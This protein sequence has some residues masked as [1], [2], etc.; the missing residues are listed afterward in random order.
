[1]SNS[2]LLD[3]VAL[4]GL[5][6]VNSKYHKPVVELVKSKT[7][8]VHSICFHELVYPAYRLE[9]NTGRDLDAGLRLIGDVKNSYSN[10]SR[11]YD[12]LF[13]ISELVI[14]PLTL[15]DLIEA[16]SLILKERDIFIEEREGYWPS[17]VDAIIASVWKRLQIVLIT[18]D[19]KLIR[20]GE[21]NGL[22]FKIITPKKGV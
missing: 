22:R 12:V 13:G 10:I 14:L 20:Y 15:S 19:E 18:N 11:N 4:W 6:F 1:V 3:T 7:T 5:T 9:S 17:I 16:Y 2:V 21:K 8:I